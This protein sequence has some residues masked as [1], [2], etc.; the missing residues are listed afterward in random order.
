[1]L[2]WLRNTIQSVDAIEKKYFIPKI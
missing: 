2:E 1:M